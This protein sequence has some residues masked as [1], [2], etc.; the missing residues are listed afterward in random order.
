[1]S[2]V[3]DLYFSF[4]AW[5]YFI[6]WLQFSLFIELALCFT[7]SCFIYGS[8]ILWLRLWSEFPQ[9]LGLVELL[10][11]QSMLETVYFTCSLPETIMTFDCRKSADVIKFGWSLFSCF[12]FRVQDPGT[13]ALNITSWLMLQSILNSSLFYIEFWGVRWAP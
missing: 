10:H 5:K 1:M 9:A 8:H 13:C 6:A 12:W 2:P 11:R 4:C 3:V 7:L